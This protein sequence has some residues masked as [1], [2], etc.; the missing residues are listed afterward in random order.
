M[1]TEK[2]RTICSLCNSMCSITVNLKDGKLDSV[3]GD[4]G[5]ICRKGRALREIFYAPDRLLYPLKRNGDRFDRISWDEAL[6]IIAQKLTDIKNK[7]GPQALAVHVGLPIT[8]NNIKDYINRFCSLY[9]TPNLAS[10]SSQCFVV[11]V[12]G[13]ALTYGAL[14]IPD[15]ENTNCIMVWGCN[16][17]NSNLSN[18]TALNK[19]LKK[20]AKLIVVDP[21]ETGIA[22]RADIFLQHKPAANRWLAL[23]ILKYIIDQEL[24]DKDFVDKWTVGFD[25]LKA[26]LAALDF[27]DIE[28]RTGIPET[29]V[30]ETARLYAT[31]GP[32]CVV[33]GNGLE[34]HIDAVQIVRAIS[35]IQAICGNLDVPGGATLPT[36]CN[37]ASLDLKNEKPE[38]APVGASQFPVFYGFRTEAQG[39]LFAD[40]ILEDKPY[41]IRGMIV[42]GGNPAL[43]YPDAQKVTKALDK[44]E[45]LVVMDLFLNETARYADIVLPAATFLERDAII[46]QRN[47]YPLSRLKLIPAVLPAQGESWADLKFWFELAKR[48]GYSEHF[49]WEDLREAMAPRM[50]PLGITVQQLEENFEG[51]PYTPIEPRKYEQNGFATRSGKVEI[52]SERLEKLGYQP[53]PA[54]E[55]KLPAP[56]DNT[57]LLST[58]ARTREYVHSQFHNIPSLRK[59]NP[60]PFAEMSPT[61]AEKLGLT[62]GEKVK[63]ATKTGSILIKTRINREILPGVVYIPHGWAEYNTNILADNQTLDPISGFPVLRSLPCQITSAESGSS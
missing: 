44:L 54:Y 47:R 57:V 62:D 49:P 7:Y 3:A 31:N 61:T 32:A 60:E 51:V 9:G 45:F 29:M 10:T 43:T 12:I 13:N 5:P 23:A 37:L 41:P 4:G 40:A 17:A 28:Q 35:I 1:K 21:R 16:P 14:A 38:A 8:L 34:H 53:L 48:M 18:M 22:R 59:T 50:K 52:Y 56:D 2:V 33:Q 36:A 39:N 6:N 63:V 30:A 46:D 58:G 25:K 42:N 15:F 26:S 55:A 20:G 27:S 24:Y 19:A 11:R